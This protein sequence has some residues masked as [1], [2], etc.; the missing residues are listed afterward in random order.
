MDTI[1]MLNEMIRVIQHTAEHADLQAS[2][3]RYGD[4]KQEEGA[5][6]KAYLL[7]NFASALMKAAEETKSDIMTYG[8]KV[9]EN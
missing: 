2:H 8:Y 9:D 5:Y 3:L 7:S 6:S 1:D 4:A